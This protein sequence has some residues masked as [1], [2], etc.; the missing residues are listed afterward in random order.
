MR[1]RCL[2]LSTMLVLFFTVSAF[3]Q[4]VEVFGGY[5]YQRT[6]DEGLNGFNAAVTGNMSSWAGITGEISRHTWGM[7][8]LSGTGLVSVDANV[9]AFRV[10][11]KFVSRMNDTASFFVQPLFGG[12]RM[13]VGADGT[14][15]TVSASGTGFTAAAGGGFDLRVGPKI[16]IRPAQLDW[17]YLGSVD[18]MGSS[19]GSTNGFRYSGGVVFKF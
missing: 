9:L 3:S 17:I 10:G 7:S 15:L 13:G 4:G 12:Y 11:P 6:G 8:M 18:V 14:G 2:V 1:T 16:A 5:S 19:S